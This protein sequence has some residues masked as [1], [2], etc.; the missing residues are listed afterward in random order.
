VQDY[1]DVMEAPFHDESGPME[2]FWAMLF[3]IGEY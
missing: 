1:A 2:K 3:V